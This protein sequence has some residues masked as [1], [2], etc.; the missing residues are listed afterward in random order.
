MEH[1]LHRLLPRVGP[2]SQGY[3]AQ[4]HAVVIEP[5]SCV[6]RGSRRSGGLRTLGLAQSMRSPRGLTQ[7]ASPLLS[8]SMR[9]SSIRMA[10]TRAAMT[11]STGHP[12]TRPSAQQTTGPLKVRLLL[13][14]LLLLTAHAGA[15]A[16]VLC[17]HRGQKI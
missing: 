6:P 16:H 8:S 5:S 4:L 7:T 9:T 13:L 11:S 1:Q 17:V 3:A 10:S 15:L 14:L 12:R 2:A